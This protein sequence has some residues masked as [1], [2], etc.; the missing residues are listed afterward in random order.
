MCPA[1]E[2]LTAKEAIKEL[3]T[4]ENGLSQIEAEERVRQYGY[5]EIK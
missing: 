4:S 5:N 2:A 3:K 1:W